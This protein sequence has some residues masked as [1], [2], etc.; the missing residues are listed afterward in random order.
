MKLHIFRR[1]ALAAA[2]TFM[3]GLVAVAPASAAPAASSAPVRPAYPLPPCAVTT[4]ASGYDEGQI[5]VISGSGG[6]PGGTIT[7]IITFSGGGAPVQLVGN[8][9]QDGKTV[10]L[11]QWPA[12]QAGP[13]SIVAICQESQS[14]PTTVVVDKIPETGSNVG[15]ILRAGG[16]LLALGAGLLLVSRFRRRHLAAA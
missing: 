2:T 6:T 14:P 9:G 11:Y 4:D 15:N 7:F 10:V 12:G 13:Y 8:V 3:A 16:V 5:A 1:T